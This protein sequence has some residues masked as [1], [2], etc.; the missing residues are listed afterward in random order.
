MAKSAKIYYSLVILFL[1]FILTGCALRR[2]ENEAQPIEPVGGIPP[3]LA[4]L[5]A[6]DSPAL[7]EEDAGAPTTIEGVDPTATLAGAGSVSGNSQEPVSPTS[8]PAVELSNEIVT[9]TNIEEAAVEPESFIPP[10]EEA[11]ATEPVIVDANT[12][13]LP[14]GGPIAANPPVSET[15][16]DYATVPAAAPISGGAYVIQPGDTL[17]HLSLAYDTPVQT[18]MLAN[19]LTSE[20][21]YAGQSLV[22]PGYDGSYSAPAY[23]PSLP[24]SG[25]DHVVT[26]GETL[27]NIALRYGTTVEA[28]A[29]ANGIPAPYIIY[30]GQPLAIA[31][32][33]GNLDGTAGYGLT[34][35]VASGETVFYIAQQYGITTQAL[36]IANGLTNPNQIQAGQTLTIPVP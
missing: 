4:P 17:F 18:I 6:L 19:G 10:A 25:Y 20:T 29:L 16:G 9:N 27:F 3:T 15:T 8:Q 24:G 22:I 23:T 21:I 13:Q 11:S 34:H 32:V 35:T 30:P 28:L 1:L 33:P 7:T 31:I 5:G 12:Q 36:V 2:D 26:E 14:S